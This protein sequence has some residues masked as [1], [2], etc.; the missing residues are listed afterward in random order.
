MLPGKGRRMSLKI[1][2]GAIAD[3]GEATPLSSVDPT[4]GE[5]RPTG[6]RYAWLRIQKP[7][8]R[9]ETIDRVSVD[10]AMSACIAAGAAGRFAFYAHRETFVLCGFSDG[11]RTLIA[12]E[13]QDPAAIAADAQR[14]LAKRKIFFGVVMIPTII[15]ISF[16]I[17][18]LKEGRRM[19]KE[20]PR[21]RRPSEVNIRR[22]LER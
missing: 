19:L 20:N 14:T 22:R 5:A 17:D 21:P 12:S 11:G 9:T 6:V 7:R 16:G 15:L 10:M 18:K 4:S 1:I 13:A 8:G 2:E 3:I